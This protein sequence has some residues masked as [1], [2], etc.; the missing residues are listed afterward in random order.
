MPR[1]RRSR[2]ETSRGVVAWRWE[3]IEARL[4]TAMALLGLS[5]IVDGDPGVFARA[6]AQVVEFAPPGLAP[7][8]DGD[9]VDVRGVEGK[10]PLDADAAGY[11]PDPEGAVV[12]FLGL[13]GDA[14]ALE[15]LDTD[16]IALPNFGVD[17]D[18][19]AGSELRHFA[20]FGLRVF[21]VDFVD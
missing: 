2:G 7:L 18:G 13:D 5:F 16:F 3:R 17:G 1:L 4:S 8:D 9:L 14:G 12:V 21:F 15:D 11:L 20:D 10:D 19:V 6:A